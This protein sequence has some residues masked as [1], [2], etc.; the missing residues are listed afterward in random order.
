MTELHKIICDIKKR[1]WTTW[2]MIGDWHKTAVSDL[3]KRKVPIPELLVYVVKPDQK[4]YKKLVLEQSVQLVLVLGA[5]IIYI[6]TFYKTGHF[7]SYVQDHWLETLATIFFIVLFV[8]LPVEQ[9]IKYRAE[10]TV[11]SISE[12][13]LVINDSV[14]VLWKDLLTVHFIDARSDHGPLQFISIH[15]LDANNLVTVFR[16]DPALHNYDIR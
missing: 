13:A 14:I 9:I 16:F 7:L 1:N 6:S 15:Y 11:L 4:K 3:V 5:T 10:R 8:A 2:S 12:A